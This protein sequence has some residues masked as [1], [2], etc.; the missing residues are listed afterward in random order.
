MRSTLRRNVAVLLGLLG[1][2]VIAVAV[3]LIVQN[4]LQPDKQVELLA[5]FTTNLLGTTIGA[6]LAFWF[7][8]RQLAIQSHEAHHK[9]LFDT[10]FELHR[11]F[12][13]FE[14]AVARSKADKVLQQHLLT[15]LDALYN[16]LPE[17]T[18]RPVLFVIYFYERLW[19]AIENKQ[20]DTKLVPE[21]F[22]DIF[23]WWFINCFETQLLP[24]GWQCCH[25]IQ[26]LKQWFDDHAKQ[27]VR[28]LWIHRATMDR[29]KRLANASKG[30]ND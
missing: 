13:S 12:N 14:M 16:D 18:L 17:E 15:K 10:A 23:Y 26:S 1:F 22:G 21:L 24:V 8:L 27:E 5:T 28:D 9:R 4:N 29:E 20:V 19:L 25:R 2:L 6:A 30:R 7:A 11:E 3:V